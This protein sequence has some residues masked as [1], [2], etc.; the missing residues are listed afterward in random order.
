VSSQAVP[1]LGAAT[2]PAAAV[3]MVAGSVVAVALATVAVVRRRW[4][5]VRVRGGSMAPAL[6]D[7]DLVLARRWPGRGV[8]RGSAGR[9]D[10]VILRR[11]SGAP[12][13]AGAVEVP[14]P[15][16]P[17]PRGRAGRWLV[18]RVVAVAGDTLPPG[19]PSAATAGDDTV[20][21]GMVVVLGD[22]EGF[23]SRLFGPVPVGSIHATVV[24]RL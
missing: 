20:P 24:R 6:R 16:G 22:S 14:E 12:V 5:T 17:R 3:W 8:L 13:P 21:A 2:A 15:G 10:V 9:G 11:P 23:D 1:V 4:T 18:K 19:V 7:G